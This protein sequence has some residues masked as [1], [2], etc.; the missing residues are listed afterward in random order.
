MKTPLAPLL[1]AA[2][3]YSDRAA[4]HWSKD[5]IR[6][7]FSEALHA[8]TLIKDARRRIALCSLIKMF[9]H[10]TTGDMRELLMSLLSDPFVAPDEV[11]RAGWMVVWTSQPADP[12]SRCTDKCG[13]KRL[14]NELSSDALAM[15]LLMEAPVDYQPAEIVL[16]KLR[17][18][19]LETGSASQYP[20]LTNALVSQIE[21]NGGSWIIEPS[22]SATLRYVGPALIRQAYPS[23]VLKKVSKANDEGALQKDDLVAW[24]YENWPYPAWSRVTQ[25]ERSSVSSLFDDINVCSAVRNSRPRILI[26][27]CG[28]GREPAL[29]SLTYPEARVEAVDL[30]LNSIQ[31]ARERADKLG[32]KNLELR[33]G[34]FQTLETNNSYD[35]IFCSGVIHHLKDPERGLEKLACLLKAGGIMKIMIYSKI[36]RSWINAARKRIDYSNPLD[37]SDDDIR[38]ARRRIIRRR[39]DL[40]LKLSHV[41]DFATLGGTRDLLFPVHEDAFDIQRIKASLSIAGLELVKFLL[42]SPK[43]TANFRAMF[44]SDDLCSDFLRWQMFEEAQPGA[45]SGMYDFWVR[46]PL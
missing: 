32:I 43:A 20:G 27:G 34:D 2:N 1:A 10:L 44:P 28:T 33:Q 41:R 39:D 3:A 46:K 36:G 17:R 6:S 11:S 4:E 12:D 14:A 42:P 5:D 9:P 29:V 37:M 18:W 13:F 24:Q 45:F 38:T 22:E 40:A 16:T 30:S 15:Q 8:F 35:V 19:L 23:P 26:A 25:P 31:F 21:L 7:A